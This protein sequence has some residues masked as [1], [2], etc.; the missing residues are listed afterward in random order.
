MCGGVLYS[1]GDNVPLVPSAF[2]KHLLYGACNS[3]FHL[4]SGIVS[5]AFPVRHYCDYQMLNFL[6][7]P[8]MTET[9]VWIK[10]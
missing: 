5:I 3:L 2:L 8:H 1:I 9:V 4:F 7:S 6:S 10:Q